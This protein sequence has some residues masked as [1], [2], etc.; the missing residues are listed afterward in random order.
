MSH[1]VLHMLIRSTWARCQP[2]AV[3]LWNWSEGETIVLS[4]G[5]GEITGEPVKHALPHGLGLSD[6]HEPLGDA[7][8]LEVVAQLVNDQ[9][10]TISTAADATGRISFEV[11]LPAAHSEVCASRK[12][13]HEPG[14]RPRNGT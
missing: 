12:E 4:I 6:S 10:G 14:T 9:R 1:G 13:R 11:R 5:P 3:H 2:D 7:V 8:D